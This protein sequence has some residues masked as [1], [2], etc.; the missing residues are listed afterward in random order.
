MAAAEGLHIRRYVP[1]LHA[2]ED[3]AGAPRVRS[4]PF[5]AR[6]LQMCRFVVSMGDLQK[7]PGYIAIVASVERLPTDL[8]ARPP[9]Q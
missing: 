3:S 7:G 2:I 6:I 8:G 5:M 9:S 1:I 4:R